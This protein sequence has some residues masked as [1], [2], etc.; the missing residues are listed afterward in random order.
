VVRVDGQDEIDESDRESERQDKTDK[1][2]SKLLKWGDDMDDVHL[3]REKME[4]PMVI[5]ML[6]RRAC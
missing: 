1:L 2:S 5:M 4:T 6:L 3:K